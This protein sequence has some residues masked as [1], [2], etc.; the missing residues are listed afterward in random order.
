[1]KDYVIR[2]TAYD[3][4]VRFFAAT[5]RETVETA[6]AAHGT[7]PVITAA[8]GRLLTAGA[9]MGYM[10]KNDTDLITLQIQCNGPVEGLTVTADAVGN[11]KGFANNPVVHLPA[12]D[13]GKLDVG[14]AVDLGVLTVIKDIGMKEPYSGQTHLVSGEIA[15]DLTFYFASSE[16]IPTSVSLGVLMEKNNTVRQA[17][18]YIIQL[19]PFATEET[20][21]ALEQKLNNF[22]PITSLLDQGFTPEDIMGKIFADTDYHINDKLDT[23]FHCNCSKERMYKAL[24]RISKKDIQDIVGDGEPIE[25]NCH[26]C[27]AKHVFSIEE[28]KAL[29]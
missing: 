13:K 12:S 19:M 6:R 8:L 15:E 22:P 7:S 14:K 20:I 4:Q 29:L 3:N 11:V 10:C 21:S 26:F 24:S 1:M 27:N 18:G 25:M 28:C 5:T 17:G 9:M 2:G 23:Q 16:Q